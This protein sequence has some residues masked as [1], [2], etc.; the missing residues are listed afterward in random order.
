[1]FQDVPATSIRALPPAL[2]IL[3]PQAVA[4]LL[5]R[6]LRPCCSAALWTPAIA[7]IILNKFLYE[8]LLVQVLD[9][10]ECC[11]IEV[12]CLELE[13]TLLTSSYVEEGIPYPYCKFSLGS[14]FDAYVSH[15]ND[16]AVLYI[17][18]V[19][20]A[21]ILNDLMDKMNLYF[22][23]ADR[24]TVLPK[25]NLEPGTLVVTV[26]TQDQ[27][28]YR[29]QV[30]DVM[31][32]SCTV[33]YI[34]YG[35]CE[36]KEHA[37]LLVLPQEF[38]ALE[39]QAVSCKLHDITVFSETSSQAVQKLIS[40]TADKVLKVHVFQ[41]LEGSDVKL[42][43]RM[44]CGD[45]NLSSELV[46]DGLAKRQLLTSCIQ[47]SHRE[48]C[49][50]KIYS[51]NVSHVDADNTFYCILFDDLDSFE[52]LMDKMSEYCSNS[53]VPFIT[54]AF[55]GMVCCAPYKD[56]NLWCRACVEQ[57][58]GTDATVRL[59]DYGSCCTLPVNSLKGINNSFVKLPLQAVRC[60]S[61]DLPEDMFHKCLEEIHSKDIEIDILAK[62]GDGKYV[63]NIFHLGKK[64]SLNE[65]SQQ[66]DYVGNQL[67]QFKKLVLDE[68]SVHLIVITKVIDNNKFHAKFD[69]QDEKF[70]RF[71]KGMN[72]F[73][74]KSPLV[75]MVKTCSIGTV[76]CVQDP[77]SLEWHRGKVI[78]KDDKEVKV[79]LVDSGLIQSY[80]L[81]AIKDL[82]GEFI[83]MPAQALSVIVQPVLNMQLENMFENT[84]YRTLVK[85]YDAAEESYTVELQCEKTGLCLSAILKSICPLSL[86]VL[87]N[88]FP[89]IYCP[90]HIM[91]RFV[92]VTV[93]C[94]E[95]PDCLWIQQCATEKQ[96]YELMSNMKQYYSS[97][98]DNELLIIDPQVDK[99]CSVRLSHPKDS[100][101][102]YRG[103]ILC[104]YD[105]QVEVKFIDFGN[106]ARVHIND[107]KILVPQF[108]EPKALALKCKLNNIVPIDGRWTN[109]ATSA[110]QNFVT[111]LKSS[112][113]GKFVKRQNLTYYVDLI[114]KKENVKRDVAEFLASEG[115][116]S[117]LIAES[118]NVMSVSAKTPEVDALQA[119][120][121]NHKSKLFYT[122]QGIALIGATLKVAL[123]SFHSPGEF[124]LAITDKDFCSRYDKLTHKLSA[125][126]PSDDASCLSDPLYIGMPCAVFD[127]K[128]NTWCRGALLSFS[129]VNEIVVCLVDLGE[130]ITTQLKTVKPITRELVQSEPPAA[131]RCTLQGIVKPLQGGKW[132]EKACNS[133]HK[134]LANASQLACTIHGC[135]ENGS[136]QFFVC[137]LYSP[138]G[139]VENVLTE[140]GACEKTS[141]L[142]QLSSPWKP[143]SYIF[144]SLGLLRGKE[145]HF[146]VTHI[147]NAS[148]FYCQLQQ[149]F[150]LFDELME[151]LQQVCSCNEQ[152]LAREELL[153]DCICFAKDVNGKW[154]RAHLSS[155]VS[156]TCVKVMYVDYGNSAIV[157]WS[158]IKKFCCEKFL[159]LPMMAV[160]CCLSDD[161]PNETTEA[162]MALVRM[163]KLLHKNSLK[164]VVTGCTN[165]KFH[166]DLFKNGA[167]V[168]DDIIK[169]PSDDQVLFTIQKSQK[170]TQR[171]L[172]PKL[173]DPLFLRERAKESVVMSSMVSP[174]D[175]H[176][177]CLRLRNDCETCETRVDG[178]YTAMRNS[179]YEVDSL[180]I[181]DMVCA[182]DLN[183]TWHRATVV[184]PL[185]ANDRFIKV[186]YI[187]KGDCDTVEKQYHVKQLVRE[188]AKWP[189]MAVPCKLA[190][191]LPVSKKWSPSAL[192][193]FQSLMN[194]K[195]EV[196]AEFL[197][198]EHGVWIVKLFNGDADVASTLV[199][200]GHAKFTEECETYS[201][202]CSLNQMKV[203][204]SKLD[205]EECEQVYI[206]HVLSHDMVC[207]QKCTETDRL[208]KLMLS[209]N[210]TVDQCSKFASIPEHGQIC[211][212]KYDEDARY[213]RCRVEKCNS[214]AS[215][216]EVVVD[217]FD[218]GN[219]ATVALHDLRWPKKEHYQMPEGC[220][221]CKVINL[222]PELSCGEIFS[223]LCDLAV[224]SD[225][226]IFCRTSGFDQ[227]KKLYEVTFRIGLDQDAGT[228]LVTL[229]TFM[230][231]TGNSPEANASGVPHYSYCEDVLDR[232]NSKV[233]VSHVINPGDVFLQ[234]AE[235]CDE[236]EVLT[237][238]M[239]EFY[240]LQ[241]NKACCPSAEML[242]LGSPCVARFSDDDCWYRALVKGVE[243]QEKVTVLFVDYGNTE[244]VPSSDIR[245]IKDKFC[246]LPVRAIHCHL[247]SVYSEF[248]SW[249]QKV[250][251]DFDA[252]VADIQLSASFSKV[253]DEENHIYEVMLRM[254]DG[255]LLNKK[256][257]DQQNVPNDFH[258]ISVAGTT[259]NASE[260]MSP[261]SSLEEASSQP[262]CSSS[263]ARLIDPDTSTGS[264]SS[265]FIDAKT[266]NLHHSLQDEKI[267][268]HSG[269]NCDVIADQMMKITRNEIFD[270]LVKG[271]YVSYAE[272]PRN[273]FVQFADAGSIL[274][275]IEMS[276]DLD[277]SSGASA[278]FEQLSLGCNYVAK[279]PDDDKF[280]R[281]RIVE[282][283]EK[284]KV[285]FIDYG[286]S[287]SVSCEHIFFCS[288]KTVSFPVQAIQC[289]LQTSSQ[290]L[291]NMSHN[292]EEKFLKVIMDQEV[293][294]TF[295]TQDENELVWAVS[296]EVDGVNILEVLEKVDICESVA[297]VQ[298][299]SKEN[300]ICECQEIDAIVDEV[301]QDPE[302][303]D[304][305]LH[306][307]EKDLKGVDIAARNLKAETSTASRLSSQ[308]ASFQVGGTDVS[309]SSKAERHVTADHANFS[310]LAKSA[311]HIEKNCSSVRQD[312]KENLA[313]SNNKIVEGCVKECYV[314]FVET[315]FHFFVQVADAENVLEDIKL[316][317]ENDVSAGH[318][319]DF[320]EILSNHQCIAR[321]PEDGLFYR[322]KIREV[323]EKPQ[324]LFIDYGNT[325][326]VDRTEILQ[327]SYITNSFP[328]QAIECYLAHAAC[329]SGVEKMNDTFLKTVIEHPITV[330]FYD[331]DEKDHVWTV[332]LEVGGIDILNILKPASEDVGPNRHLQHTDHQSEALSISSRTTEEF[333]DT[334]SA[335]YKE[336]CSIGRVMGETVLLMPVYSDA[337]QYFNAM[338]KYSCSFK[339]LCNNFSGRCLA[340]LPSDQNWQRAITKWDSDGTRTLLF[341]DTGLVVHVPSGMF[342]IRQLPNELQEFPSRV[343]F[344]KIEDDGDLDQVNCKLGGIEG[345]QA[346]AT[347]VGY[348]YMLMFGIAVKLWKVRLNKTLKSDHCKV[349]QVKNQAGGDPGAA[350][351]D[352]S[353]TGFEPC[354]VSTPIV[355]EI[356]VTDVDVTSETLPIPMKVFDADTNKAKHEDGLLAHNEKVEFANCLEKIYFNLKY[357]S[358]ECQKSSQQSKVA[359]LV[360]RL[361]VG[362]S[363]IQQSLF[364]TDMDADVDKTD[365][366]HTSVDNKRPPSLLTSFAASPSKKPKL[367]DESLFS[368]P[369]SEQCLPFSV[370]DGNRLCALP[371]L[372]Y[373]AGLEEAVIVSF[374]NHPHSFYVKPYTLIPH[375]R[376][377]K[378]CLAK[379]LRVPFP[380]IKAGQPCLY[381]DKDKK[382]I[383]FRRGIVKAVRKH[384][385][386]I[387][388]LDSGEI[389][390]ASKKHIYKLLTDV[391]AL[392]CLSIHCCLLGVEPI[393]DIWSEEAVE[394]FK[395]KLIVGR[396]QEPI[397]VTFCHPVFGEE[398][399]WMVEV[400]YAEDLVHCLI[401]NNFARKVDV[402]KVQVPLEACKLG[403]LSEDLKERS[404]RIP[405][406]N[407]KPLLSLTP[408]L[409][410]SDVSSSGDP[411]PASL[412]NMCLVS[413]P[414]SSPS[415]S[416]LMSVSD[417]VFTYER[418]SSAF[419]APVELTGM[420]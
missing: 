354:D 283:N 217:F 14:T 51:G 174:G 349:L 17:Q 242:L 290:L 139:C 267:T 293:L 176:L 202:T 43:V 148:L 317:V 185:N 180:N 225:V 85:N 193:I 208:E 229:P 108:L 66:F 259:E 418:E 306:P 100:W 134:F 27:G 251:S 301:S 221:Q 286:N 298:C 196:I 260:V 249:S 195:E 37:D 177:K 203:C 129:D 187:D 241:E 212:A 327:S 61:A 186:Q 168:N 117:L 207:V 224:A 235:F 325:V 401:E 412:S 152:T 79:L 171:S 162:N 16:S 356:V 353:Q 143:K 323:A 197:K 398:C 243:S 209:I 304:Q 295:V 128:S 165:G 96:C 344:C 23:V 33:Q 380:Y 369:S 101:D 141:Y 310:N 7:Q 371:T 4:V 28:Y 372:P 147:E 81:K 155:C 104:C 94:V 194:S 232:I 334:I 35:D 345:K 106:D 320:G 409:I 250:I 120:S 164:G 156:G 204:P 374:V 377:I 379:S 263:S 3:P 89:D 76:C 335:G 220:I 192:L 58:D 417:S 206:S 294:V 154:C 367:G 410:L 403:V 297:N 132:S 149:N 339:E 44:T 307:V 392:P 201:V 59:V 126:Y 200:S 328:D 90:C 395:R 10:G 362:V 32:D 31:G 115:Y 278:K 240:S 172:S 39:Y 48:L 199:A 45:N 239:T 268:S 150:K 300:E 21:N 296:L 270:G 161:N 269:K 360:N 357:I 313:D 326:V 350:C 373:I 347:F 80:Q 279:C 352:N 42:A 163:M 211:L 262:C 261:V 305:P 109:N 319:V 188:M 8:Q 2:G 116:A 6:D 404:S 113:F 274:E 210:E 419:L 73:Y 341:V 170:E 273:F 228:T 247:S 122:C 332:K 50:G 258:K 315:P 46:C 381:R 11:R 246:A 226:Q 219:S 205:E 18:E 190:G 314:S 271:C 336:L 234:F 146:Y 20:S 321:S 65:V 329:L 103:R 53:D 38:C 343:L 324:I 394:F 72:E 5:H 406:S 138:K 52:S 338:S 99:L 130:V 316:S 124:F 145:D 12:L 1:M 142:G 47:F 248:K 9:R 285:L 135:V 413:S 84:C 414:S 69:S 311:L 62:D 351:E 63:V 405:L 119:A 91:G 223:K 15:I 125:L 121:E 254:S 387:V 358:G 257:C 26:Y 173:S 60:V 408:E 255:A 346:V 93:C 123:C 238:T 13:E 191:I 236:L 41:Q 153:Q 77:S 136:G 399:K 376:Y 184:E 160:P 24:R 71:M 280:Y 74:S 277:V 92:E 378:K 29:A 363:N 366:E 183:M 127:L 400:A 420:S 330:T 82:F 112:V 289:L 78:S 375:E 64:L 397:H 370:T 237:S 382:N 276:V 389:K 361:S 402:E 299:A 140:A 384:S 105:K 159:K 133:C 137:S 340:K 25:K 86:S 284:P 272:N 385:A 169:C 40:I 107:V 181:G 54:S 158:D 368:K 214:S 331:E 244:V 157:P 275:E 253:V 83:D 19:E 111:K 416:A 302:N 215:G 56:V 36:Q 318:D 281:A 178:F 282:L 179:D 337:S 388:D 198:S 151:S 308:Q 393:G 118:R 57:V 49:I 355:P 348:T 182:R 390:I 364:E 167:R 411:L 144:S 114:V 365:S 252:D 75:Q 245:S 189:R 213:Y 88:S 266:F 218:Y 95:D 264:I 386:R 131:L 87:E 256:Y 322:S 110:L 222:P 67:N 312:G 98:S 415:T 309:S 391:M 102:W 70:V 175:F 303:C 396:E 383:R 265:S 231:N 55:S 216:A 97:V 342:H 359:E 68:S 22:S 230:S 407:V 287:A 292:A 166:L 227:D 34:D 30:I 291:N 288:A 333:P 233:Y